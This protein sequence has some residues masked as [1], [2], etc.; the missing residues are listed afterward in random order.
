MKPRL[1]EILAE[2][3]EWLNIVLLEGSICVDHVHLYVSIPPK[4]S[5]AYAMKIL[6]GKSSERLG[7]EFP[8]LL[9]KFWGKHIW[10]RGYFV[11]TIGINEN[12]IRRYIKE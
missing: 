9:G 7:K 12:I 3:C 5:P 4:V 6:K 11:S 10:A 1:K 8:K 2:L